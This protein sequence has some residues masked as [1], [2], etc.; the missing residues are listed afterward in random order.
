YWVEVEALDDVADVRGESGDVA[1]QVPR[2]V[3][4]VGK[5]LREIELAQVV[6]G[7]T[8]NATSDRPVT[9]LCPF[10]VLELLRSRSELL[11]PRRQDCVQSPK[12]G[13]RQH[14]LLILRL[15]E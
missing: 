11:H 15:L 8:V 3:L 12:H 1:A 7:V 4:W 2:D 13:E 10:E 5:E 14:D 6:E 9:G